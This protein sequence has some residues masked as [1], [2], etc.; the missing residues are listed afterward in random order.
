MTESNKANGLKSRGLKSIG[1]KTILL[2]IILFGAMFLF[3]FIENIK[4]VTYPL[5]KT[6]FAISYEQQ[7]VMV[8]VLSFSYVL[9]CLL[10]GIL[11][12]SQGVKRTVALGFIF[13]ILGLLGT[14]FLPR[15]LFVAAALFVI[16]ASFGI[17]E[18]SINALATQ[19][20]TSRAALLMSL[21]HFFYGVGSSFSPRVAGV[22]SAAFDWRNVY[23]F[24]IP[25]VVIIFIPSLFTRFPKT[26]T[27]E[28]TTKKKVSF[29]RALKTPMVWV[30]SIVLG[31]M[32]SVELC[33]ANW[34]GLYFQDVYFLDPKTSGAGFISNFYIL[35]TISR[36]T[37]GFAIEKIGYMRS[38]FISSFAT[39]LVFI[40]GFAFGARGIYILPVL[41]FFTAMFW[42]ILLATAMGYFKEDS[43]VMTSAIIVLAGAI[44]SLIQFVAGLT[45]R[46]A[47]P[48]W[49]YRSFLLYAVLTVAALIV[50]KN[51]IHHPYASEP[52]ISE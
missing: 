28:N 22:I 35:F 18:V 31:L 30:F 26:G 41:G 32:V 2:F 10:G 48:A 39:I 47:G 40:A 34:A 37:S 3:G 4:G 15:F 23:L 50:L 25:L 24:S 27:E 17:F 6:D 36:L 49:G 5:I 19:V 51:R 44:N 12:G 13:M 46:I 20:F 52:G 42:P 16:S 11:I 38:I 1:S 33:S 7:G 45:N 21:L 14:F 8:S 43:P 29:M 9:F